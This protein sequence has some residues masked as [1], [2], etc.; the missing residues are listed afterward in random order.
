M[1]LAS[2]SS[3][4]SL[5]A[6]GARSPRTHSS[7]IRPSTGRVVGAGAGSS[8]TGGMPATACSAV[9][10]RRPTPPRWPRRR[11]RGAGASPSAG[12]S[13]LLTASGSCCGET[14][15]VRGATS[16]SGRASSDDT[17]PAGLRRRRLAGA[18]VSSGSA[19]GAASDAACSPG[20]SLPVVPAIGAS[21]SASGLV[22]RR[23]RR[24]GVGASTSGASLVTSVGVSSVA[25]AGLRRRRVGFGAS[26]ALAAGVSLAASAVAA[27]VVRRRRVGAGVAS[28]AGV[29]G[30]S[31]SGTA[32][33]VRVAR[34]RRVVRR[35]ASSPSGETS[36][37]W[38][39]SAVARGVGRRRRRGAGF[40]SASPS[41]GVGF[42]STNFSPSSP[43]RS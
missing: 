7:A 37:C 4:S 41:C 6:T 18:G 36:A 16:R 38:G 20:L 24:G 27:F 15:S 22:V 10:L 39:A 9:C 5:D 43:V 25:A 42:S 26:S 40:G 28:S 35:G 30:V 17:V 2:Q 13:P 1:S 19:A 12:A 32:S 34:R 11:R 31:A 14:A 3:G 23:L 8:S 21:A 33:A 29:S